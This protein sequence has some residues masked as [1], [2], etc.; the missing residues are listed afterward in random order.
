MMTNFDKNTKEYW[1]ELTERYFDASTTDA[2]ERLLRAFAAQTSDPDF[3][4][5][6]AVMGYVSAV[7]R[8]QNVAAVRHH[9]ASLSQHRSLRMLWRC[10]AA[11]VLIAAMVWPYAM[12]SSD[13]NIAVAYIRGEKVTDPR[14]VESVAR[15]TID[16]MRTENMAEKQLMQM[17]QDIE[18]LP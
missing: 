17:F 9:S 16:N 4:E 8:S 5:L 11:A 2:E 1:L 14:I 18:E 3:R 15:R 10:A 6:R 7:R 13:E 12:R